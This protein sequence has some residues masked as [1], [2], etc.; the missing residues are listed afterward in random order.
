VNV[1]I[2][3]RRR[4]KVIGALAV[5]GLVGAP[6][7]VLAT[8][9]FPDVPFGSGHEE[10]N[11]ID[12]AGIVRG[13]GNVGNFC[14]DNPVTRK[15]L[16]QFVSRAGGSASSDSR[17]LPGAQ[18]LNPPASTSVLTIDVTVAGLQGHQQRVEV[19]ADVV[20]RASSTA[21]CPC[22]AKFFLQDDSN[23][24]TQFSAEHFVTLTDP[25]DTDGALVDVP[26]SLSFVFTALTGTTHTYFLTGQTTGGSEVLRAYGDITATTYP[27]SN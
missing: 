18:L 5:L 20:V 9:R 24:S 3:S 4:W 12:D 21:G 27:F 10:I 2:D 11:K 19:N 6:A 13:C 7:A 1:K 16:A 14:P 17:D 8:D 22:Q 15:Q 25:T 23:P 26:I